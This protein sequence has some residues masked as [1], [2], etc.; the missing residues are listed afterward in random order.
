MK[1][2]QKISKLFGFHFVPDNYVAPVLRRGLYHRLAGPGHFWVLPLLEEVK[3]PI[4][5]TIR[6]D[7]HTFYEVRTK[8][9]IPLTIKLSVRYRFDPE[10]LTPSMA[11]AL[12]MAG[13][14]PKTIAGLLADLIEHELR[15][16]VGGLD[17]DQMWQSSV[18]DQIETSLERSVARPMRRLGIFL[19]DETPIIIKDIVTLPELT[20]ALQ[21]AKRYQ[22]VLNILKAYEEA[23]VDQALVAELVNG[24]AGGDGKVSIVTLGELFGLNLARGRSASSQGSPSD[25]DPRVLRF[26]RR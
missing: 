2:F 15:R 9:G 19:R 18:R 17:L 3:E 22:I 21:I 24:L 6:G 25:Q 1:L 4:P 10:V 16:Q 7:T 11:R 23:D 26:R 12:L 14:Q 13:E 8:D 20:Q 5:T